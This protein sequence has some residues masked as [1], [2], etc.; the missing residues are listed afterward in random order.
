ME[1]IRWLHGI[2]S[3]I[4]F[5]PK[6][7]ILVLFSAVHR[8]APEVEAVAVEADSAAEAAE[9][10]EAG[11]GKTLLLLPFNHLFVCRR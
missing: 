10:A 1:V 3:Q 11:V 4:V 7:T 2:P 5:H 6:S 9:A 8:A